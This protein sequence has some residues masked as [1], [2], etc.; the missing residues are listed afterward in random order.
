MRVATIKLFSDMTGKPISPGIKDVNDAKDLAYQIATSPSTP[1]QFNKYPNETIA[2]LAGLVN[3]MNGQLVDELAELKSYVINRLVYEIEHSTSAKDRIA[4]LRL[5]G[6]VEGVDAFQK[7]SE[8]TIKVQPIQ[9][10]E[11]ELLSIIDNVEY[12]F[13]E[14]KDED[15]HTP[16]TM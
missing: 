9:E 4:A 13:V 11:R 2:Y 5:L 10:V 1:I 3:K 12:K 15:V 16:E 8:I 14:H 6:D 7:R